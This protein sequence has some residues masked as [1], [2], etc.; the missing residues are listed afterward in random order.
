MDMIK[1][2]QLWNIVKMGIPG[3]TSMDLKKFMQAQDQERQSWFEAASLMDVADW[4][5]ATM[6]EGPQE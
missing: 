5:V 1:F 3:T 6:R 2:I 4:I